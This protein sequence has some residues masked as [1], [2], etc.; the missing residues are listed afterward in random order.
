MGPSPRKGERGLR[1]ACPQGQC[2]QA[3]RNLAELRGRVPCAALRR[4]GEEDGECTI[5]ESCPQ[6]PRDSR[7]R[8]GHRSY[9]RKHLGRRETFRAAH[10]P[11]RSRPRCVS[12]HPRPPRFASE[13]KQTGRS[14][15]VFASSEKRSQVF[16]TVSGG[17]WHE[18]TS[19]YLFRDCTRS[20]AELNPD[21]CQV[22]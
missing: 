7:K 9:A 19:L 8:R 11:G 1:G 18:V 17:T 16:S 22:C 5:P 12:Q 10:A 6:R 2:Q 15:K 13:R 14:M 21:S 20:S 4:F 3:S